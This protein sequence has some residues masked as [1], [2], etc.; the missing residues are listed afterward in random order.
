MSFSDKVSIWGL[1]I[2]IFGLLVSIVGFYFSI[3][4]LIRTRKAAEAASSAASQAVESV[5]FISAV[6]NMQEIVGRCRNLQHFMREAKYRQSA[7]IAASDLCELIARFRVTKS[8]KSLADH[9]KWELIFL[10]ISNIRQQM[11]IAASINRL[12]R[13]EQME[14]IKQLSDVHNQ[15]SSLAAH[16]ADSGAT[17]AN[18]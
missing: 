15:L 17:H 14:M 11:E 9:G 13:D 6:S 16:T 7:V 3:W 12:D 5:Q 10:P 8:G 18:T 2:S 1:A 4:Q